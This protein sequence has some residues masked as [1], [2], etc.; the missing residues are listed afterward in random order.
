M[1]FLEKPGIV[2]TP[3]SL[4]G[5][6]VKLCAVSQDS[7]L[8]FL[9]AHYFKTFLFQKKCKAQRSI[10]TRYEGKI[11][12]ILCPLPRPTSRGLLCPIGELCLPVSGKKKIRALPLSYKELQRDSVGGREKAAEQRIIEIAVKMVVLIRA[13]E[14]WQMFR[15]KAVHLP[16]Q[17]FCSVSYLLEYF[18]GCDTESSKLCGAV[19]NNLA[20]PLCSL[21]NCAA[22]PI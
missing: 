7:L 2:A 6:S 4:S 22:S 14:S 15:S 1:W 9:F 8:L 5:D 19:K 21:L 11:W 16:T 10:W 13:I 20:S 12:G 18:I 17:I 3:C